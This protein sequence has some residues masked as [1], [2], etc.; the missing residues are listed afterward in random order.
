MRHRLPHRP[1]ITAIGLIALCLIVSGC[2]SSDTFGL[3]SVCVSSSGNPSSLSGSISNSVTGG[4][5]TRYNVTSGPALGQ[6]NYDT[7]TGDFTYTPTTQA[8]GYRDRFSV[9]VTSDAGDL[10]SATIDVI[11]GDARIMP[12]GDSI[13][14]GV[15]SSRGSVAT[16][17]PESSV[18]I[19]YRQELLRLLESAGYQVNFVG[20]NTSGTS[21]GLADPEHSGFP[22]Q[23][24]DFLAANVQNY[25]SAAPADL[26]LLHAG[27]ND[28]SGGQSDASDIQSMLT[29]ISGWASGPSTPDA[30]T[31]VARIVP[32]TITDKNNLVNQF[33]SNLDNIM[34]A[35]W[36][37]L[38]VV[39]MNAAVDRTSDMTDPA[40]DLPGVH[41]N[42]SGY[43]KMAQAWFTALVSSNK[44][45]RCN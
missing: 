38:T 25:L 37:D 17:L 9:Q 36:P 23:T 29:A 32:S 8:R 12:L 13:T 4:V 22:G 10:A 31:L 41:P 6:L 44:V 19:G 1:P 14:Q 26:V 18:A 21:A 20:V 24:A 43:E 42:T 33:N 15:V 30:D 16:D 34:S 7:V 45:H 3:R 11:F 2:S 27:T 28:I 35:N 40:I 39:D 5:G